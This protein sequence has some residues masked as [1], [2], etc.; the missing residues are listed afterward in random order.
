[1]FSCKI[2][3]VPCVVC[4]DFAVMFGLLLWYLIV[5]TFDLCVALPVDLVWRFC[6]Y[7]GCWVCWLFC[8]CGLYVL[9]DILVGVCLL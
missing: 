3:V 4:F 1:M 9:V 8:W 6:G 7:L 2:I 5:L